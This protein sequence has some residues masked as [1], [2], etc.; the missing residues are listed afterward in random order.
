MCRRPKDLTEMLPTAVRRLLPAATVIAALTLTGACDQ[1]PVVG[2]DVWATVDGRQ[3]T[4]DDVDRA[5]RRVVQPGQTP[6]SED[7]AMTVKLGIVDELITQEVLLGKAQAMNV[8]VTDAEIDTAYGQR[9]GD[10]TNEAFQSELKLRSLSDADLREVLRRELLVDKLIQ[11]E[12]NDRVSVTDQEISDF[13]AAN[14]DRFNV[15]ETQYRI[16][17]I[18]VTSVRDPGLRNRQNN[19][20]TTPAQAEQKVQM[21]MERLKAGDDFAQ[22]AMDFSEDPQSAP[23]GGDLGFVPASALE[24]VPPELRDVVLKSEPGNVSIVSAGGAH[25]LV[26]LVARE[27]AGLRDLGTPGVRESVRTLIQERRQQ[28]LQGAFLTVAR[29]EADIVNHQARRI[30]AT[31]AAPPTLTPAAPGK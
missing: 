25:T 13:Y 19:D 29:Q 18:V 27:N 5:F 31:P 24:R 16:A 14:R 7:E 4:Q 20:A 22:L 11:Q 17:Q 28:L 1:E 10:L 30:A 12:V 9:K 23:Q 6:T 3:I 8:V 21:L 15:A 26:L 2:P